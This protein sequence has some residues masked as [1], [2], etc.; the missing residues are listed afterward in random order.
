M[1][2][3]E[4][5]LV[6]RDALADFRGLPHELARRNE[7]LGVEKPVGLGWA[8]QDLNPAGVCGNAARA[9]AARGATHLEYLA[10]RLVRLVAEVAATPLAT[11]RRS[12]R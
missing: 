7:L 6:R 4:P 8:S 5:G 10:D 3:L 2:H 9:E 11:L 1:L 12:K